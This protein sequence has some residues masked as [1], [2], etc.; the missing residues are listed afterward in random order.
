MV[1]READCRVVQVE[2]DVVVPLKVVSDK[3]EYAA[4]TIRPKI[5]RHLHEFLIGLRKTPVKTSSH[6]LNI[7]SMNL[8]DIDGIL[9]KLAIDRSVPAV[10]GFHRGGT[11][12]SLRIFRNFLKNC[13]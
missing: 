12:E 6:N 8:S 2:S 5:H 10:S 3:A 4:R 7:R 9:S 13:G 11:S 1:A